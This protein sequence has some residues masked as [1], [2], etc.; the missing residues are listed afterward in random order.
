M[1]RCCQLDY[2]HDAAAYIDN[3]KR[4]ID[5]MIDYRRNVLT[6]WGFLRD[7]HGGI[8]A[9]QVPAGKPQ[10]EEHQSAVRAESVLVLQTRA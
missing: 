7:R 4:T 10:V 2:P 8:E 9:A 1:A 5:G 6:V 3:M